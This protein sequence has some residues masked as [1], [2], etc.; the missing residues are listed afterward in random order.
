MHEKELMAGVL[1]TLQSLAGEQP[2]GAVEIALGPGVD[3]EEAALAWSALTD[4]TPLAAAHVTWEQSSDL[5]RCS[6][7]GHEY[8]GDRLEVCPY[9]GAD[10]VVIEAAPP[11]SL[12][13][14]VVVAA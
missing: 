2:I 14:W 6:G 10:G 4:G 12:G 9:C 3:Q 8:T 7:C 11:V 5:L 13:H 1:E